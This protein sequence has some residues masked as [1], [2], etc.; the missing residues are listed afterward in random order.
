MSWRHVK[1]MARKEL[2]Q[3]GRDRRTVALL[4]MQPVLLLVL[5]GY[6]ASFDVD[7]I[8]TVVV[9][10]QAQQ[11]ADRLPDKFDVDEIE[12]DEGREDAMDRLRTGGPMVAIVASPNET[13]A[14]VDGSELFAARDARAA[15]DRPGSGMSVD[16]RFNPDLETSPVLVPALAGI[17]LVFVGTMAT[18]LGV[19][20]E[21]QAGTMEQLAVMPLRPPDVLLGKLAPYVGI[22]LVDLVLVIWVAVE[23]FDVP[24]RGSVGIFALGAVVFLVLNLAVG[25][26]VSSVSQNQGQAMQLAMIM[27]LPQILLSGAIF[28]LESMAAGVRWLGY[29]MPLTWFVEVSR[30]VMLRDATMADLA[31]PLSILAVLAAVV[32]ALAVARTR[33]DLVPA[34]HRPALPSATDPGVGPSVDHERRDRALAMLLAAVAR[35]M[36]RDRHQLRR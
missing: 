13:T 2:R 15:L 21:R 28:P 34:R 7:E 22:S 20:R 9:G 23:V 8:R 17:V 24:F 36:T 14:L 6:A 31:L 19:V 33:R 35:E 3:L 29:F 26:L 25:L 30:G 4:I 1:A 10:S 32:F 27:A 5:F 11:V 16:V 12:P 18:S